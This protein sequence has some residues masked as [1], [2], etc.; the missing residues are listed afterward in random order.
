MELVSVIVPVYNG[1]RYLDD[2]IKSI[3]KQSYYNLE[4]IIINDGSTDR[5]LFISEK[6]QMLDD[7]IRIINIENKGLVNARKLGILNAKGE[8][9]TFI[10][11]DDWVE[12]NMIEEMVRMQKDFNSDVVITACIKNDK[13]NEFIIKNNIE[14]GFYQGEELKKEVYTRMLYYD[15]FYRFGVLQYVW[16][17]LYRKDSVREII[18]LLDNRISNGEDVSFVY[19][20]LLK[21]NSVYIS[22]ECF[23]HY[24]INQESMT[25]KQQQHD[26]YFNNLS[27]LYLNLYES[28][29]KTNY[30]EIMICQLNMYFC[31]M[32]WLGTKKLS[33][34]ILN[35]PSYIFPFEE[36][37]KD[38]K[39]VIYGAGE[40]GKAYYS[41][42]KNIN[43]P[44]EILWVDRNYANLK[45]NCVEDPNSITDYIADK[46]IIAI[47]NERIA[48]DVIS[49]LIENKITE[50]S[51]VWKIHRM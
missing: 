51:I 37:E 25:N 20:L 47:E 33:L 46:I 21:V 49:N 43:F 15:G 13:Q 29:V 9:V 50:N 34:E 26:H 28:F 32:T 41:Q 23:Y 7:R 36:I 3:I 5:S 11:S 10:D 31:Y 17:K 40:V 45:Q 1:E 19:P 35:K 6:Y 16:S 48:K 42:L 24:R 38:T 8:Y 4:L 14:Q 30:Y 12:H 44:V 18:D 22:N 27:I 2:C 39:I